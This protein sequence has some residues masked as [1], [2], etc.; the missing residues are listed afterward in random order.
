M[1]T[2]LDDCPVA[3]RIIYHVFWMAGIVLGC[4]S[5]WY[6]AYSAPA[7]AWLHGADS[8]YVFLG[9]AVGYT[10]AVNTPKP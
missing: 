9:G 4:I 1:P 10:A 2:P 3:R 7:P 6:A 8:V 5:V